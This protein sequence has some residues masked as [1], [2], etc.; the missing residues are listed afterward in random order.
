MEVRQFRVQLRAHDFDSTCRFYG[1]VLALPRLQ[2]WDGEAG[3]GALY[4]LGAGVIEVLGRSRA[5]QVPGF[6]EAFDYRGPSHKMVLRLLVPSAERAYEQMAFRDRN[7]PGGL[8]KER[9]GSLVFETHD[10]DGVKL[11]FCEAAS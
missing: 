11:C 3:R 4:Q 8:R 7:V 9:D 2:N 10:P 6:D 5:E 1:E